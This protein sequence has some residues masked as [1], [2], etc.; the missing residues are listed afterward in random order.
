MTFAR[1]GCE[2]GQTF[3]PVMN[4]C[5]VGSGAVSIAPPLDLDP[6]AAGS[7]GPAADAPDS[8]VRPRGN[9]AG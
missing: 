7:I 6:G 2:M 8:A 9:R 5:G 1:L 3:A 4:H